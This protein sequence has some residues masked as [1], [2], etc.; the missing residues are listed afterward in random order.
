MS[1]VVTEERYKHLADFLRSGLG[2]TSVNPPGFT[3]NQKRRLRQQAASFVQRDCVLFYSP[4]GREKSLCRVVVSQAE[5]LRLIHV[6]HDGWN[7]GHFGRDKTISKVKYIW[8]YC[9]KL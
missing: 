5:K 4:G 3:V 7:G 6:C 9:S 2:S 1:S 8:K